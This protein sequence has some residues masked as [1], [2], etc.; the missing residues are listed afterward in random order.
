[1]SLPPTWRKE[2]AVIGWV[3]DL[4]ATREANHVVMYPVDLIAGKTVRK[5]GRPK[6]SE[7]ARRAAN[8]IHDAGDKV[9]VIESLL[10][11]HYPKQRTGIRERAITIAAKRFN[12]NYRTLCNYVQRA[13]HDRRRISP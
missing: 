2:D 4:L 8:P 5:R 7:G 1:M 11:E 6:L 9:P 13:K 3:I 12:V 10:R